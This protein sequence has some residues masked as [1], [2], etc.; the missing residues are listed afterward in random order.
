MPFKTNALSALILLLAMWI[1]Q[2]LAW[3]QTDGCTDNTALNFSSEADTDDGSCVFQGDLP[4]GWTFTPTPSSG[5]F[6][7]N[8][9]LDG[10][11]PVG[12]PFVLGAF[13][14]D[15]L[16]V[17]IT[18]PIA[19]EG[20][21]YVALAIYGDDLTTPEAEGMQAGEAFTLALHLLGSDTT[22]HNL[23]VANSFEA[24]A[25]SN[26]TPMPAYND[27]SVAY[28]F[29]T[30]ANCTATEAC[31]YNPLST[32]DGDCAFPEEGLDCQGNCL[33]DEDGDGV[34]D[35]DEIPGCTLPSACN[36]EATAT[37]NDGSCL[38]LDECGV[39]GGDGIPEGDCD[40][41][42]NVLDAAGVCGGDCQEDVDGDGVCDT[43]D[44]CVGSLDACG[45][46]NGPGEIYECG[47]ADIPED[48]CDCNGN[49]LDALGVCGGPCA[50]DADGDG[51]C[52]DVDDCVG[53]YDVVGVC[54]GTCTEDLD[55]DGVCDTEEIFG[56]DNP[57]AVNFEPAA[58]E[59]DGSCNYEGLAP[60]SGFEVTPG[61]GSAEVVG[62][63]TLDG[64]PC[65]GLDWVGAFTL[66]GV[67]VGA[68]HLTMVDGASQFTMALQGDDPTT[69]GEP[70]SFRLFDASEGATISY[71]QGQLFTGWLDTQGAPLPGF[72][73][74]ATTYPFFSPACPDN[75]GDGMCND[76]DACPNQPTDALGVCGGT[77]MSDLN[78]NGICDDVDV[79]GCTYESATNFNPA[80]TADNNSCEFNAIY[81]PTCFGDLDL[82]GGVGTGDLLQ[83]LEVFGSTCSE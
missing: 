65:E 42:G 4:E 30:G 14:Q 69:V 78:G 22:L 36:Y 71:N 74:P 53:N 76:E 59:N 16:C 27:V 45:V 35:E 68:T 12:E 58:T 1:G 73:N 24:W 64:M 47:C 72:S 9:T 81:W 40:C 6:L 62:T 21:D 17:G 33:N 8:V 15:G 18:F 61:L 83:F 32:V 31:N 41:N 75:D 66:Q 77:C 46:C 49:Q 3:S 38:T 20:L 67:C 63:V 51:V 80:A 70:F 26:G 52:D 56:C 54:N 25:N 19:S 37:D 13:T 23:A 60:P 11:N 2:P 28:D 7:G 29:L 43:V 10:G 34:C 82:N 50:A 57:D 39:C 44:D 5:I 79:L 48:D 55:G